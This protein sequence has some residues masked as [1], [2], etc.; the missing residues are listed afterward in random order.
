MSVFLVP[1]M[2]TPKN[3]IRRQSIASLGY[4][5]VAPEYLPEGKDEY[6]LRDADNKNANSYRVLTAYEIE[7]LVR[8]RNT[9]ENWSKILVSDAF[10][11]ELVKNCKFFGL[12]RI[13][14]LE[15][16]FLEFSD[17]KVPVGL[18]N[19]TIISSDFGDN[20]VIENVNYLSHYII[21]NDV[22]ITNV[23]E[24]VTSNYAKFGNGILKEGEDESRRIWLELCNEN[25]GRKVIPFDGMTTGDAYLWTKFRDDEALMQKF[26]ELTEAKYDKRRGYYGMIGD[27]TIIKNCKIIKDVWI[28]TDAY[29]K[30]ANKLKNITIN[31]ASGAKSQIGE[32]TEMVNGIMDY[33]CRAFYGVKAVRFFMASN[34]QL[35]YGARLINSY[36]GNNSTIS[37]CEVLNSLIFPA[38]EQH[39]NN[40]FLCASLVMG[41]SNIAAGATIGSN[42]NSRSADG[43]IVAGRGFW[44]GLC[45]SLKHNSKFASFTILAKGDYPVELNIPIPFSLVSNDVAKDQVIVMPGFW[46]MYNMYALERNVGKYI[47]RDRRK[48]K[49]QFLE[50]N[51][52]A[53]DSVNEII[54]SLHLMEKFVGIAWHKKFTDKE[55][56]SDEDA[57]IKGKQ[58][59][60][61]N[62]NIV[63][64]LEIIANGFENSRR[65][66]LIVKVARSYH[67]FKELIS[68]YLAN[69]LIEQL[70]LQ[71][72]FDHEKF[73]LPPVTHPSM[74]DWM[75]VGG[76]LIPRNEIESVIEKIKNGQIN[77]WDSL[78]DFY[79]S[80]SLLYPIQKLQHAITCYESVFETDIRKFDKNEFKALLRSAIATK[81]WMVEGI[82][83]SRAKDYTNPFRKMVYDT[84]EEM[85]A[86]IGKLEENSFIKQQ[87]DNLNIYKNEVNR[88]IENI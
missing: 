15:P 85:N 26:K 67:L 29:L 70:K 8:N 31:S 16:F 13:G 62:D 35:K 40:S 84:T 17:L 18:Y 75:N 51:Y 54:T 4:G 64:D 86:V 81:E 5:F 37:C 1:I 83:N 50:Y 9:A 42:H 82:Y 49:I 25:G 36:L 53:P 68:F 39:H 19:S 88:I 12:V 73:I 43:E 46:F 87:Q 47:E 44:P 22:I 56:I 45:V 52:L 48:T 65:K 55:I 10:N 38:H 32:G 60:A 7:V 66:V 80:Q 78:H 71:G 24:L 69:Q 28:G 72:T 6:Y 61:T 34:S 41:Q 76:Q 11:P 63:D 33:G 3:E 59:L 2:A 23:N 74:K 77:S 58:L 57:A 21:G 14:K 27:R 79:Q 30:G 20:V